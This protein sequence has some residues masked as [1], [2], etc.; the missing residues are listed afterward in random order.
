MIQVSPMLA[1]L[2]KV[3]GVS[4]AAT[5]GGATVDAVFLPGSFVNRQYTILTATGGVSGTFNPVVVSN[6][7]NIQSTLT[8]DA[9]DVFLNIKLAFN[10]PPSGSL[11]I[12]QQNVANTLSSFFNATGSIP[13]A[14]AALSPGGLTIASGELGTGVIQSSI[15]ADDLFLNLLLDP[16]I[17]GRAGGFTNPGSGASGYADDDQ[18]QAY[19]ARRRTTPSERDAYAM[20]TKAPL[21]A[22]A[23][24]NRWSVWGA[25]YG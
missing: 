3:M 19:A 17:A 6:V 20:A 1:G 5:L 11:N 18:A 21:L 2:T 9:N 13:A 25:A 10:P 23:P 24:V 7:T 16:T 22:S 12:N 4:G 15:K 8:Y 14:F